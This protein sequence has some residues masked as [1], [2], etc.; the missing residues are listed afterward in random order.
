MLKSQK[1]FLNGILLT[2]TSLIIKTIGVFFGAYTANAIGEAGTGLFSLVMSVYALAVTAASA[3]INLAATRMAAEADGRLCATKVKAVM[4]RCLTYS[5][6][7]GTVSAAALFL[8]ADII[9]SRF[10]GNRDTVLSLQI[11]SF[12]LPFIALTAAMNGYFTAVGRVARTAAA[13][14]FEQLIRVG[15]TVYGLKA[16]GSFG[17]KYQCVAL[18]A[19]ASVS[20]LLSFFAIGIMFIF[21][22][23]R[24][25]T[26]CPLTPED[27]S[28]KGRELTKRLVSITLPIA[29]SSFIRSGLVTVEHLLIP[30]GLKKFGESAELALASYGVLHGMVMPVVLFPACL[31]YSFY[32]L[33]VP[34]LA[35]AAELNKRSRI[36][37]IVSVMF[38]FALMYSAGVSGIMMTFSYELGMSVYGSTAA[39]DYIRIIAPLITIMYLDTAVDTMLKGLNEQVYTMRVNIADAAISTILVFLLVPRFGLNGYIFVMYASEIINIALSIMRL[40]RITGFRVGLIRHIAAPVFASL[41]ACCITRLLMLF[42]VFGESTGR[43]FCALKILLCALIYALLLMML[44]SIGRDDRRAIKIMLPVNGI[45]RKKSVSI[46]NSSG[47]PN[48]NQSEKPIEKRREKH[49]AGKRKIQSA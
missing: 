14:I 11:L 3:G 35:Q 17:V 32:G 48:E 19:G 8:L 33:L 9:G 40:V 6:I 27:G 29:A 36:T 1:F 16:F 4:K 43:F 31:I 26:P 45:I 47:N 38:R 46:E 23:K 37:E 15:L 22:M 30:Y 44:G 12:S 20:E 18:V 21:D 5:F 13:Q 41:G 39:A 7:T 42:L 25:Q 2:V 10:L 49:N 34:E 24:N 28:W